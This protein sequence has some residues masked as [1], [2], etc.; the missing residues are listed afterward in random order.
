MDFV[1]PTNRH[2]LFPRVTLLSSKLPK[3]V[4]KHRIPLFPANVVL[5]MRSFD[6]PHMKKL[7]RPIKDNTFAEHKCPSNGGPGGILSSLPTFFTYCPE[8]NCTSMHLLDHL[9]H[10]H[11]FPIDAHDLEDGIPHLLPTPHH[12]TVLAAR[13]GTELAVPHFLRLGWKTLRKSSES[14]QACSVFIP[15]HRANRWC[16]PSAHTIQEMTGL[17]KAWSLRHNKRLLAIGAC[18]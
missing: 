16:R 11:A 9:C 2:D 3:T 7:K 15:N 17:P 1:A 13:W 6:N 5:T 14:Y 4:S 18:T 10:F 12:L 8:H